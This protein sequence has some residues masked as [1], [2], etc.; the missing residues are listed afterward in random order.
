[1]SDYWDSNTATPTDRVRIANELVHQKA[2]DPPLRAVAQ[3]IVANTR[4]IPH[5]GA[6]D[7]ARWVRK[8]IRYAQEAPGVEVLQGPYTTLRYGMGDCDDLAILWATLC[9]S[10]GL[11]AYVAGVAETTEPDSFYHAVGYDD[12]NGKHYELS[13]DHRYGGAYQNGEAFTLAP[14]S[15]TVVWT[16][17]PGNQGFWHSDGRGYRRLEELEE[18]RMFTMGASKTINGGNGDASVRDIV[19]S[20]VQPGG[21]I[22]EL[23]G[24]L[25]G[26]FD[27]D[28]EGVPQGT[29]YAQFEVQE[30]P[31]EAVVV[32]GQPG[33]SPWLLLLGA[34]AVAGVVYLAVK[35]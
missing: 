14:G 31:Q 21:A 17:V 16:P 28:D 15:I 8:Q 32:G 3:R 12:D 20:G 34:G 11:E 1:M 2:L 24:G 25:F 6:R 5:Q 33:P 18:Q 4:D 7:I 22:S 26:L 35:K 19:N 30:D 29:N 10:I 27:D 23:V 9:R 13:R